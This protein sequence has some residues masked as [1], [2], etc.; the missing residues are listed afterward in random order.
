MCSFHSQFTGLTRKHSFYSLYLPGYGV[1]H[2]RKYSYL[3]DI[4]DHSRF[5]LFCL[6]TLVFIAPKDFKVIWLSNSLALSV[7]DESYFRYVSWALH[8][9]STFLLKVFES[10]SSRGELDTL[11]DKVCQWIEAGR[12]FSVILRFPPPIK[13]DCNDITVCLYKLMQWWMKC[14]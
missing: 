3:S 7:P 5:W 4:G 10:R 11:C 8:L 14:W 2:N 13:T 1:R 9:I 6:G 12:W